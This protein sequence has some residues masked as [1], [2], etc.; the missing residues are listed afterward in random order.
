MSTRAATIMREGLLRAGLTALCMVALTCGCTY[1]APEA[2]STTA[3]SAAV[4]ELHVR[5]VEIFGSRVDT[6]GVSLHD[7][8]M[9]G[10]LGLVGED[11]DSTM[12]IEYLVAVADSSES[13][14]TPVNISFIGVRPDGTARLQQYVWRPVDGSLR[15]VEFDTPVPYGAGGVFDGAYTGASTTMTVPAMRKVAAGEIPPPF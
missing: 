3:P 14:G 2:E 12:A 5:A 8:E 15:R 13:K 9:A 10:M 6:E 11:V 7:G 1:S 4:S